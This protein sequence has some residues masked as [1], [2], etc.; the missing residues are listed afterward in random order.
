MADLTPR[1]AALQAAR[2]TALIEERDGD[3]PPEGGVDAAQVP[4]VG[5]ALRA[6][7][8]MTLVDGKR[9]DAVWVES[10]AKDAK[11]R[12]GVGGNQAKLQHYTRTPVLENSRRRR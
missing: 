2:L 4:E 1:V 12:W 10:C 7:L 5:A 9:F 6:S 11:G 3:E 8:T